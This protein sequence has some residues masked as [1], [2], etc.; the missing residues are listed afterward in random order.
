ML[1]TIVAEETKKKFSFPSKIT[2]KKGVVLKV[3]VGIVVALVLI[4]VFDWMIQTSITSQYVAFYKNADISRSEYMKEL[5]AQYGEQVASS[6]LQKNAIIQAAKERK[7]TVTEEEVTK[8]INAIKE[9]NGITTDEA[10]Q[11]ALAQNGLTEAGLRADA[12]I[13]TMLDKLLEGAVAEPTDKEVETYF[14]ENVELFKGQKLADVKAQIVS[15]L[16]DENLNTQRQ[17]WVSKALTGYNPN[18]LYVT[19][20]SRSYKFLKSIDLVQR[21]FSKDP[22]K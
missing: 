12:K 8:K 1:D 17:E 6:M 3:V 20:K 7:I 16:R 15:S 10:F 5:E 22:T 21:L 9:S 2:F 11:A 13:G 14:T 4:P 18:N 19:S